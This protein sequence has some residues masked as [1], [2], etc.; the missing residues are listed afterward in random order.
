MSVNITI[1][2][3]VLAN[4]DNFNY[5]IFCCRIINIKHYIPTA[6]KLRVDYF[7]TISL[8]DIEVITIST[9]YIVYA[10]SRIFQ[11]SSKLVL[12]VIIS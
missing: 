4:K 11:L 10:L 8:M 7:H 2:G 5:S 12:L 1:D 3:V 9:R 6:I